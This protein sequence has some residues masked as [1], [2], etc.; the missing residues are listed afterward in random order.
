MTL[1]KIVQ[2][3]GCNAKRHP[4]SPKA[5]G[6]RTK[7]STGNEF[8]R[9]GHYPVEGQH[10]VDGA[11]SGK[12]TPTDRC[13]RRGQHGTRAACQ[14]RRRWVLLILV[15]GESQRS[16]PLRSVEGVAD[17]RCGRHSVCVVDCRNRWIPGHQDHP[18]CRDGLQGG[19]NQDHRQ[20]QN[21]GGNDHQRR[22]T[23]HET[24]V[25]PWHS[26]RD[27]RYSSTSDAHGARRNQRTSSGQARAAGA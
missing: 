7:R 23:V 15:K 1:K 16:F 17:G 6:P 13:R 14:R 27:S 25:F 26:S 22:I 18:G 24:W 19:D 10:E 20:G 11:G 2:V 3:K 9:V 4:S 21:D 8:P 5:C 12:P